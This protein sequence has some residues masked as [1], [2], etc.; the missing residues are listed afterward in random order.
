MNHSR[1]LPPRPPVAPVHPSRDLGEV[2]ENELQDGFAGDIVE[3]VLEIYLQDDEVRAA[4]PVAPLPMLMLE[5]AR[6]VSA[7]PLLVVGGLGGSRGGRRTRR[8][9]PRHLKPCA[10]DFLLENT[11]A[12]HLVGTFRLCSSSPFPWAVCLSF[13]EKHSTHGNVHATSISFGRA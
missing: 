7:L 11:S 4:R 6:E 10:V 13:W 8:Q 12:P 3:C 2:L 5:R 1:V 9:H